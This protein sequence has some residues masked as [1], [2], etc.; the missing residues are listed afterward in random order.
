MLRKRNAETDGGPDG[1]TSEATPIPPPQI[2]R[3]GDKK[4]Q[5]YLKDK[6]TFCIYIYLGIITL[7]FSSV[8]KYRPNYVTITK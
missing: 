5:Q 3:A 2:R 6:E 7:L 8:Y 1:G 4:M